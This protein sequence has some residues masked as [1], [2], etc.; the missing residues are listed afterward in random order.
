[1]YQNYQSQQFM[2]ANAAAAA[3]AAQA[4]Q[5]TGSLGLPGHPGM[6]GWNGNHPHPSMNG[7]QNMPP[8]EP[9]IEHDPEHPPA[10]T[11]KT[12]P[13]CI[14]LSYST[15][16]A[17]TQ[18]DKYITESLNKKHMQQL[19]PNADITKNISL[20]NRPGIPES[21]S[22]RNYYYEKR[23][24]A[25]MAHHQAI[26]NQQ[27]TLMNS[28][29]GFPNIAGFP[30]LHHNPM[31]DGFGANYLNAG[32]HNL[33]AAA[34]AGGLDPNFYA[35]AANAY[36]GQGLAQGLL[37]AAQ[38]NLGDYGSALPSALTQGGGVGFNFGQQV[39][40]QGLGAIPTSTIPSQLQQP[41]MPQ[42]L[43]S[44]SQP[45]M[46]NGGLLQGADHALAQLPLSQQS[47]LTTQAQPQPTLPGLN[48]VTQ[49]SPDWQ[50]NL[51]GHIAN[52]Q[53][54]PQGGPG[55]QPPPGGNPNLFR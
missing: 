21:F 30:S 37:G 12:S 39:Q 27:Q 8:V 43:P 17:A 9:A 28:V 33:N 10:K 22:N 53:Q 2:S 38:H 25:L 11:E 47:L 26:M 14:I 46:G 3:A 41:K 24:Q 55:H 36:G 44:L 5:N 1:M 34:A 32:L 16:E 54:N 19:E 20:K 51:A 49:I 31:L 23:A 6:H 50:Q 48:N 52:Q 18:V 40:G 45:L 42:G 15:D 4:Y 35:Q 13:C 7:F 29:H